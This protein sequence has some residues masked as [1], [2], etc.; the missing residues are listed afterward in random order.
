MRNISLFSAALLLAGCAS[1]APEAQRPQAFSAQNN[2]AAD[3]CET[4][5]GRY[6]RA[7]QGAGYCHLPNGTTRDAAKLLQE[8][9]SQ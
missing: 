4:Q 3:Y 8:K 5:G 6:E 2:P 1:Q 9:P 7:L